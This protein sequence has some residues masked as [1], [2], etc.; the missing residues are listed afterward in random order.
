[1][2]SSTG[3]RAPGGVDGYPEDRPVYRRP[4][5]PRS[6]RDETR[7]AE[8]SHAAIPVAVVVVGIGLYFA[9]TSILIPAFLGVV[10]LLSGLSFLSTRLNPLS[11]HF[12]LTR[13][14]SWA[15][16]GVVFLGALALLA[17]TYVLWAR[18][19]AAGLLPHL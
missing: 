1:M 9:G 10:L 14:P 6:E 16:I 12:Y 13:K 7:T 5:P 18:G 4:L 17:E 19:G 8:R 15:A 3:A 11:P 2:S